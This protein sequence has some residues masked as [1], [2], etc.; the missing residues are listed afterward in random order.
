[1]MTQIM[2]LT[3]LVWPAVVLPVVA[4]LVLSP[5]V[6]LALELCVFA[7]TAYPTNVI[8]ALMLSLLGM[9]EDRSIRASLLKTSSSVGVPTTQMS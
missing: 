3:V 7:S 9:Q 5:I 6:Q 8:I 2:H 4:N 1:M